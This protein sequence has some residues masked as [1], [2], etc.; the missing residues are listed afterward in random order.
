MFSR[1]ERG[2]V[3][4]CRRSR[5]RSPRPRRNGRKPSVRSRSGAQR[6]SRL[7]LSPRRPC[8]RESDPSPRDASGRHSLTRTAVGPRHRCNERLVRNLPKPPMSQFAVVV[9]A[10]ISATSS[11]PTAI[12]AFRS[13]LRALLRRALRRSVSFARLARTRGVAFRCA[14]STAPLRLSNTDSMRSGKRSRMRFRVGRYSV[15]R[16]C[17]RFARSLS[18]C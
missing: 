17:P 2:C 13:T 12:H 18:R 10:S 9:A 3:A 6:S 7:R 11:V 5:S 15:A 8:L 16:F 1:R 14:Q 4:S